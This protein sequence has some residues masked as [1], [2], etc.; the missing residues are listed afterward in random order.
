[1]KIYAEILEKVNVCE[2]TRESVVY[3]RDGVEPVTFIE[4]I[5]ALVKTKYKYLAYWKLGHFLHAHNGSTELV[6]HEFLDAATCFCIAANAA[7]MRHKCTYFCDLAQFMTLENLAR[8]DGERI[9]ITQLLIRGIQFEQLSF[10]TDIKTLS[11]AY[12]MLGDT[13]EKPARLFHTIYEPKMCYQ[14]AL[15]LDNTNARAYA[16]MARCTRTGECVVVNASVMYRA[17]LL[18]MAVRFA[19]SN[20]EYWIALSFETEISD[21]C[22]DPSM[23]QE[24]RTVITPLE[25]RCRALSLA[26]AH[27]KMCTFRDG[28]IYNG[29]YEMDMFS[30]CWALIRAFPKNPTLLVY[31]A[32]S[33]P[34]GEEYTFPDARLRSRVNCLLEALHLSP[35]HTLAW[36]HLACAIQPGNTLQHMTKLVSRKDAIDMALEIEPNSWHICEIMLKGCT[37]MVSRTRLLYT[38][39]QI[40]SS[41]NILLKRCV[42]LLLAEMHKETLFPISV[43]HRRILE[44]FMSLAATMPDLTNAEYAE[45]YYQLSRTC[46]REVHVG[47]WMRTAKECARMAVE[48]DPTDTTLYHN[49]SRFLGPDESF[50][51]LGKTFSREELA[52]F[53]P[54]MTAC[55][56]VPDL[57]EC[58]ICMETSVKRV[59]VF[60]CEHYTCANCFE[61]LSGTCPMCRASIVIAMSYDFPIDAP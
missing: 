34:L 54:R 44:R 11:R 17:D 33:I 47:L 40:A 32:L 7:P 43:C 26:D 38:A 56:H 42:S 3:I 30:F 31:T 8:I 23:A 39:C 1:M 14:K 51:L 49:L 28:M 12:A 24:T 37:D 20:A 4:I 21:G 10:H 16:G 45:I 41:A 15:A 58:F 9:G 53:N 25:M 36:A 5:R 61:K 35:R 2:I 6:R 60:G 57:A 22:P 48:Y 46:I 29:Q 50:F 55:L 19:P 18:Q 13:L 27:Y 52:L 59:V